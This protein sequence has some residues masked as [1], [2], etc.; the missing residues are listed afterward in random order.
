M[1][2]QSQFFREQATRLRRLAK[3]SKDKS[4]R[5]ELIKVAIEYDRLAEKDEKAK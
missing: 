1:R 2:V 5:D 3:S 4:I